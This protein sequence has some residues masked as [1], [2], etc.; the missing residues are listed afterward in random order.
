MRVYVCECTL[1][2][3]RVRLCIREIARC[4]GYELGCCGVCGGEGGGEKHRVREREM[5]SITI[6]LIMKVA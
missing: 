6:C 1:A 4:F 5:Q 2:R 3:A